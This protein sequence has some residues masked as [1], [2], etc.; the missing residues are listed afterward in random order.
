M[1]VSG[2]RIVGLD[3]SRGI[4]ILLVMLRHAF[5]DTSPAPVSLVS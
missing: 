2:G 1:S 4:T 5:P 3:V